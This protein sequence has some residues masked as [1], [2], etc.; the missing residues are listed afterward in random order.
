[1][2][3]SSD[4]VSVVRGAMPHHFLYVVWYLVQVSRKLHKW[5]NNYSVLKNE[6]GR[7][8]THFAGCQ[9]DDDACINLHIM[10]SQSV[11]EIHLGIYV[12]DIAIHGTGHEL[13]ANV[14]GKLF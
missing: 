13:W 14:T 10:P 3:F 2:K 11:H 6:F 7:L 12:E 5:L 8:R 9:V 4:L 1:M